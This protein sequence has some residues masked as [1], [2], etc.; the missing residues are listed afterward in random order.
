MSSILS[1]GKIG[2]HMM[3]HDVYYISTHHIPSTTST[4]LTKAAHGLGSSGEYSGFWTVTIASFK[5]SRGP[6]RIYVLHLEVAWPLR[7]ATGA[8][9]EDEA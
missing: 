6:N 1:T 9:G 8:H 3:L 2:E 4:G 5:A 7:L